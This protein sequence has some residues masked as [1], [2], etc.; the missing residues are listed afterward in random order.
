[1][2]REAKILRREVCQDACLLFETPL[3][4]VINFADLHSFSLL[5]RVFRNGKK[6]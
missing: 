1:M 5:G 6:Y 2:F 3:I 4:A